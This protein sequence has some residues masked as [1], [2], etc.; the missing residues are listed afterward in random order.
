MKYLKTFEE[1]E[2]WGTKEQ[3]YW[4]PDS[5]PTVDLIV[6]RDDKDVLL[7]RRSFKSEVEPGKWAFPG[8]FHDTDSK[9]GEVWKPGR[10]TAKEAAIRELKEE[11]GLELQNYDDMIYVGTYEGGRRDPRDNEKAWSKSTAF[12]IRLPKEITQEIKGLDDADDAQWIPIDLALEMDLA[13][14]H[15]KILRDALKKLII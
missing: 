10:E 7:I 9:K 15:E 11:T 1:Q 3:P 12:T 14:D 2:Y 13:F 5:N 8:G 4:R 6:I